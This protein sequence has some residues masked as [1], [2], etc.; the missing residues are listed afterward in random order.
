[1]R[2]YETGKIYTFFV[3]KSQLRDHYT[4]KY[5]GGMVLL[6]LHRVS[7]ISNSANFIETFPNIILLGN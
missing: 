2:I 3:S 7:A 4:E 1:M 5:K 6:G